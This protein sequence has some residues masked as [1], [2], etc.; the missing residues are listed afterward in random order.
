VITMKDPKILLNHLNGLKNDLRAIADRLQ[1]RIDSYP[2]EQIPKTGLATFMQKLFN[3]LDARLDEAK[4]N[5][6]DRIDQG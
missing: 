2:S 4:K 3:R 1:K 6:N 5:M